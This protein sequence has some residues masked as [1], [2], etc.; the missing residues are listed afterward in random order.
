M[1]F[2]HATI[3]NNSLASTRTLFLIV[4]NPPNMR[5]PITMPVGRS[6]I[7]LP[8]NLLVKQSRARPHFWQIDTHDFFCSQPMVAMS[9]NWRFGVSLDENFS[10]EDLFLSNFVL[11]AI[12]WLFRAV[13]RSSTGFTLT[14]ACWFLE[15]V[16]DI[17][18]Y[19]EAFYSC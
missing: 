17:P 19:D 6:K 7:V 5:F 11:T 2:F 10:V 15:A 13:T 14:K 18:S 4:L 8:N 16:Y 12:A 3:V 9:V 1:A